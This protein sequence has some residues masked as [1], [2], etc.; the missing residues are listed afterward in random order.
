MCSKYNA[1]NGQ[2]S[3]LSPSDNL[4]TASGRT[5]S[6]GKKLLACHVAINISCGFSHKAWQYLDRAI[7]VDR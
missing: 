7:K 2:G 4:S 6:A 1:Y 3:V 5:R